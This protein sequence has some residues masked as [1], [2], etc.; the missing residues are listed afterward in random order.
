MNF[1]KKMMLKQILSLKEVFAQ[2][3][4]NGLIGKNMLVY[5]QFLLIKVLT[6]IL[7]SMK[8]FAK[9][10]KIVSIPMKIFRII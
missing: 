3:K 8:N 4:Q 6:K 2:N 7:K 1:F 9:L 10:K 5:I